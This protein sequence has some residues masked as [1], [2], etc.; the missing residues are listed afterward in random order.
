MIIT[1]TF[2]SKRVLHGC[3]ETKGGKAIEWQYNSYA[4]YYFNISPDY[5]TDC[6]SRDV[7]K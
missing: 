2:E 3:I 4:P 5:A 6:D 1:S 7:K